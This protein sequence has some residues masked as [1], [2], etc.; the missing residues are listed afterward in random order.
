MYVLDLRA[1]PARLA[2]LPDGA[3][4]AAVTY[5]AKLTGLL[6]APAPQ[7]SAAGNTTFL[8]G[9]AVVLDWHGD[10]A[11]AMTKPFL[12]LFSKCS[13]LNA[14]RAEKACEAS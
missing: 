12:S 7:A 13:A 8:C 3:L 6:Y 5:V 14:G 2:A 9:R 4:V 1:M 10:R 11:A